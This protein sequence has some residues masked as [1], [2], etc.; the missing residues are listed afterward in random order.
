MSLKVRALGAAVLVAALLAIPATA[1]AKGAVA[2]T[3]KGPGLKAPITVRGVGE[4]GG[5]GQLADLSTQAGL[6]AAMFGQQG[7]QGEQG[8]ILSARPGG[9]LGPRYAASYTVPVD[10][11]S[12]EVRQDLYPYAPGGP[13]TYTEPGQPLWS[14][15]QVVGGWFRAP[16]TLPAVLTSLG[17]PSRAP[18]A[19]APAPAAAEVQSKAVGVEAPASRS[20]SAWLLGISLSGTVL[21]LA[22]ALALAARHRRRS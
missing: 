18:L 14:G 5:D 13:V 12:V 19:K 11:G 16:S 22:G 9:D 1:M 3:I 6:F 4:P 7:E 15:E 21:V 20:S 17:V 10:N 2:V 8:Q